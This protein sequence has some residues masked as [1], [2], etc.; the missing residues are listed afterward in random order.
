[1]KKSIKNKLILIKETISF[2]NEREMKNLKGGTNINIQ[3]DTVSLNDAVEL[4]QN[5]LRPEPV[6]WKPDPT[7]WDFVNIQ[8]GVNHLSALI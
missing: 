3:V 2:L 8:S 1:M 6:P 5:P 7:P 4:Q